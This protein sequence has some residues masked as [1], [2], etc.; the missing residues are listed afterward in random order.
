M[1][2]LLT[3]LCP[4]QPALIPLPRRLGAG[5]PARAPVISASGPEP[6]LCAELDLPVELVAG[7][8]AMD[9]VAEAA[10]HAAL[11]A[12]EA[13]AG[14]AEVRHR[15]QLAVDGPRRVPARVQRVAGFL[16]RVLV[17]EARVDVA[18][19]ICPRGVVLVYMLAVGFNLS[20]GRGR[21]A[22]KEKG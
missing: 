2:D 11:A 20:E 18:N 16:R 5:T 10:A 6:L 1:H 21:G 17:L 13:A 19:E 22:V 8:L 14:F 7:V 4:T 3:F 15:R 12:V 9:E